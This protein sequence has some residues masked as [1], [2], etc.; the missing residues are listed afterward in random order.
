MHE[1]A[2]RGRRGTGEPVP[3]P[4]GSPAQQWGAARV[5]ESAPVA[6]GLAGALQDARAAVVQAQEVLDGVVEQA[7]EHSPAA[8][9]LVSGRRPPRRWP[10]AVVAAVAGAAAGAGVAL[11]L[12]RVV[13][14]DAPGALE[15]DQL[16]A[17]V[18]GEPSGGGPT[19]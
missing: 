17:V 6:G 5:V 7:R 16:V 9:A 4:S 3:G 10:W 11:A 15:P 12:Q 14:R 19:A 2:T 13:G 18:D 1:D 8:V